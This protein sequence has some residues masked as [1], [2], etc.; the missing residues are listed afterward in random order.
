MHMSL[1]LSVP[2]PAVTFWSV[3]LEVELL[4]HGAIQCLILNSMERHTVFH[5]DYTI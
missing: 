5:N 4:H 1:Q 2:V 3:Y